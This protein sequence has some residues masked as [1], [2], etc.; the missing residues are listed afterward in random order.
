MIVQPTDE[1]LIRHSF[2]SH[3]VVSFTYTES[4]IIDSYLITPFAFVTMCWFRKSLTQERRNFILVF[5]YD[6]FLIPTLIHKKHIHQN[7]I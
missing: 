1:A 5:I 6:Y 7:K 2:I 3:F 4:K